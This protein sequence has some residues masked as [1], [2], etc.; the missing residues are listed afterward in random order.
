VASAALDSR[1][2]TVREVTAENED[3]SYPTAP[4]STSL[5]RWAIGVGIVGGILLGIGGPSSLVLSGAA[6]LKRER[7][8]VIPWI[9]LAVGLAAM[10]WF[11]LALVDMAQPSMSGGGYADNSSAALVIGAIGFLLAGLALLLVRSW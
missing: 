9:A 10:G 8:Q 11:V 1:A 2:G 3:E 7:G 6:V 4:A 5:A